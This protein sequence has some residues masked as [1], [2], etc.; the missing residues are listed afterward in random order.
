MIFVNGQRVANQPIPLKHNDKIIFGSKHIFQ[1][2]N[3]TEAKESPLESVQNEKNLGEE[4]SKTTLELDRV[5][6]QFDE[7]RVV[8]ED[9][10]VMDELKKRLIVKLDE[11]TTKVVELETEIKR[12]EGLARRNKQKMLEKR[13][14]FMRRYRA[15]SAKVQAANTMSMDLGKRVSFQIIVLPYYDPQVDSILDRLMVSRACH[16]T[17]PEL[18]I[19]MLP[20]EFEQMLEQM[21]E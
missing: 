2:I 13:E 9:Q 17:D 6:K 10:R 21:L 1:F 3:P 20:E 4:L 18:H 11:S 8:K 5:K 16:M 14:E 7:E 15:L 12:I 19:H